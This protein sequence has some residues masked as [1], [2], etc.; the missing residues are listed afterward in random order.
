MRPTQV[1]G[2]SFVGIDL[3]A[4]EL[5]PA[6]LPLALPVF[7]SGKL[8]SRHIWAMFDNVH[9]LDPSLQP[10]SARVDSQIA[11]DLAVR[12]LV[13]VFT[14]ND[15]VHNLRLNACMY[16]I[17]T[18]GRSTIIQHAPRARRAVTPL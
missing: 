2:Q 18:K 7:R 6:P 5:G 9:R 8:F 17:R 16:K 4:Q 14:M 10:L 15:F 3:L 12:E 1:S 13:F 11:T